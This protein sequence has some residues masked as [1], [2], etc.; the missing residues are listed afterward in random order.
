M[1][2]SRADSV[3]THP[4]SIKNWPKP[5]DPKPNRSKSPGIR[6]KPERNRRFATGF[7]RIRGGT[8][9]LGAEPK[10]ITGESATSI[11]CAV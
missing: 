8:D 3:K 2:D 10:G 6:P 4:N 9:V 5:P 1:G 7:E 11:F